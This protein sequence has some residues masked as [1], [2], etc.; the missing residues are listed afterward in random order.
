L[1]ISVNIVEAEVPMQMPR[2]IPWVSVNGFFIFLWIKF[3]LED[4][5]LWKMSL[6]LFGMQIAINIFAY[7]AIKIFRIPGFALLL[8][9]L[10]AGLLIDTIRS[11]AWW[12]LLGLVVPVAWSVRLVRDHR[13]KLARREGE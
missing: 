2:W 9:L 4:R 6:A 13:Q 11:G 1:G 12:Q 5:R 10:A 8:L 3:C 7:W